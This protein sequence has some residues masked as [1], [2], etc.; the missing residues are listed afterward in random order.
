MTAPPLPAILIVDDDPDARLLLQ[1]VVAAHGLAP[2]VAG[3]GMEAL[4]SIGATMPDLILLDAIMP[5][6]D[7]F[8]TCRRIKAIEGAAHIPVIF[9]TGLS[10]PE[11]VMKG[12]AAGGVDYV[13]KPLAIEVLMARVR[14]HLGNAYKTRSA[15]TALD[16]MGGRLLAA[17]ADGTI[18]WATGETQ[19]LLD[20]LDS[21]TMGA[22][23]GLLARRA[24]LAEAGEQDDRDGMLPAG[25]LK[26]S[27]GYLGAASPGEHLFSIARSFEGMEAQMLQQELGLTPREA[28]VLLWTA[29][30]KSNK[31][32]SEIL[33]ISS[34]TVNKHLDHIFTKLG[35]EN[36]AAA[37]AVA[38]RALARR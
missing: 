22:L 24:L 19:R 3:D 35:V 15:F 18:R 20:D 6:M 10:Q 7:G 16:S 37:T 5:G 30:G 2:F 28:D 31:D 26:F 33:N 38:M 9:M 8:E 36:R 27:L 13:T 14:V 4:A 29:R 17:G 1:N 25:A 12:L 34:R 21:E 23:R 11:H 32:M